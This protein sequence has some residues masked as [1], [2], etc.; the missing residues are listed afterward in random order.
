MA[1]VS[2]IRNSILG[3]DIGSVSLHIV[4]MDTEGNILR[5]FCQFHKG[6]I[7]D[8]FKEAG[9]IFDLSQINAIACT[10][11]SISLNKKLV[12]YFNSQVAIIE[13]ARYYCAGAQSVLH[14]GAEKFMLIK[15]DAGGNYQSA[16][17]N[18]SCAAGTGSFLDQQAV[19]LNLSGIEELCD[20]ASKNTEEVPGIASRCAVFSKTDII[21]AQQKGFSVNAICDSL[22]KGLAENIINTVFNR[23]LPALPLLMTGGVSENF[24]V[25]RYLEER[26]KTTFLYHEDSNLFG[27]IG[28]A[29]MLLKEKT[30]FIPLNINSFED[31]FIQADTEKLY[32]HKPLSLSLSEY[33]DFSSKESI[34]VKAAISSHPS[35]V[36]VDIYSDLVPFA[37][38]KVFAGIDIGS[39]STKAI[40]ID[41]TKKPLAGFYTYTVGKPLSA[42]R[43]ILEAI[44]N[45]SGRK[46]IRFIITGLG[47]TGSGR[48]FIGKILN[49]DLIVDE[50]T[51]HARAAYEL[52][53]KT[54]TIIEI[55]GQDAKFT[56]MHNGNVTFSQMN[57]VCAAGTGSFLQEQ[58]EK[59]GCS[60]SEY[61]KMVENVN[62]PLASDRCAV[63][64]ERDISQLLNKGYTVN[65]ILATALHSVTEN[66]LQKV[67][68]E[69]SIGNNICF[70]GATA[71][72]R[73]LVAAFEQ[74]LKKP[75]NVSKYCH[76][77]GALGTALILQEGNLTSTGFRGIDLYHEEIV[78]DTENC[79]LCTN[80]CCIS[81]A[82]VS[83]EKVAYGFMCGRDYETPHFTSGNKTGFDLLKSRGKIFSLEPINNFNK[84]IIIG[85]PASLHL[86]EELSLWKRFFNN[87]SIRT[88]TSEDYRDPLK[89]GKC[90]AGA[91]FCSPINS[92]FGHVV[93]LSD[94]VDYIF[95]PILLQTGENSNEDRGHYCYYTQFSASLVYTLK[96]N[97]IQNKC[98]SPLLSFPKGKYHVAQ[99]LFQCLK[100]LLKDSISYL[101]VLNAFN[102]ALSFYSHQKKQLGNVFKKQFQPDKDISVVLLGRPYIVLSKTLNK[103]IPDIFS[104]LGIKT[105]YQDMISSDEIDTEDIT[106][107]LKKVP[108]YFVT[109]IL[110]VAKVVADTKN[111]YPVL[112]T[113]FKCA[114]DSFIIEYFKKIFNSCQ[115]P[116]LILQID[117]HDS[118]LGYETRIEAA[119]RS[120]KNHALIYEENPKPESKD[121]LPQI[122]KNIAGKTLL[123]P[124]WDPIVSPLLVS[125]LKRL[126]IDARLMKSSDLI[127]KKSMAHNSGQCLP[128]NIIAQE[129]IEY[130]EEQKLEPENTMLWGIES[131]VSCN[132]RLYPEYIKSILENYGNGLEKAHVYSGLLTHLEI[133]LS[134]C[135]YA[136]FAYLLGGLIRM[137]GHRIRPYEINKGDTDQALKNTVGILEGAFLGKKSMEKA[138]SEVICLFDNIPRNDGNRPKVALF[139][140]FYICDNDIMNQDLSHTIEESGGEVITTPYTDV[141]KMSLD[142]DIRRRIYRGEYITAAQ[143]RVIGSCLKLFEDKYYRYFEKYLGP[144]KIINPKNLEKYLSRFNINLY[145]SGESYE[146]ILKI[147]YFVEN[148]QDISLFVQ[149][150]PAF[151]CPSLVTEA[152]TG[153]ITSITGVPVVTITYDGTSDYKNDVI[154]PYLQRGIIPRAVS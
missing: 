80:N 27:A 151:C 31:I 6:N 1:N 17:V 62:A 67:A 56:L 129:F 24:V 70:Q 148:Y 117:E 32:F 149:A 150:N 121:I 142:N 120:F 64:M 96:I 108:W 154:V 144:R 79:V 135:Y 104:N 18:S 47:T 119:I 57:S 35:E 78:I 122:S 92:I 66:Y 89:A 145:H 152:M 101:A 153:E 139:G 97:D 106:V 88:I 113:A 102:E 52:N 39:T 58:A 140:D 105:F 107:L 124:M 34:R 26:L 147:F 72:N 132:L 71:K 86:F 45:I 83:G 42:V 134:A 141:V 44:D 98:L 110:E 123:Y 54:D 112:V 77:T 94:K 130:I 81:L 38:Y 49:A 87:L 136:Y 127:I 90:L 118:N 103:G 59:L 21:H 111:L 37:S 91:E 30:G 114:P 95:L 25:R 69:A 10:S 99:K 65:E 84:D 36:E 50:I 28:A 55:G 100:P 93:Y 115:K 14:I 20:R 5:R 3:I 63:F 61:A 76:L 82:T 73:S 75:I 46:K 43:S 33:P 137:T 131:K 60:L 29:L 19:R 74:R 11:S 7:H 4:Q 51:S 133:S 85:I 13:A 15:F 23:E 143:H 22:C 48:K 8:T 2:L 12:K 128:I 40:L 109:K 125:N 68:T 126:G 41:E 53:P 116:Y 16:K 138:V 146:N 9:K